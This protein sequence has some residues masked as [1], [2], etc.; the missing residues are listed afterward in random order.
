MLHGYDVLYS[1]TKCYVEKVLYCCTNAAWIRYCMAQMLHGEG[2]V[3]L[4][5]CYTG[6]VLYCTNAT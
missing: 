6:K 2:T 3:L 1:W 4:R 5:E